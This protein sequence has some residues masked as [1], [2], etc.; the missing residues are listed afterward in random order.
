MTNQT[1][2]THLGESPGAPRALASLASDAARIGDMVVRETLSPLMVLDLVAHGD[3]GLV[4]RG[5]SAI[6]GFDQRTVQALLYDRGWIGVRTLYRAAG[7]E[8][9]HV[10]AVVVAL[11]VWQE[12]GGG[13]APADRL[14]H[15]ER[16]LCRFL[17]ASEHRPAQDV[18]EVLGLLD[19]LGALA[20]K[21][22]H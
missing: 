18:D 15:A 16:A 19:E 17:T 13:V 3:L 8:M 10:A 9:R 12:G 14:R 5:F 4:E 22:G 1:I 7:F 2:V 6:T 11:G 21:P 20:L